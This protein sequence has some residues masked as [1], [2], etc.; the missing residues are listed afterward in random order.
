MLINNSHILFET[1]ASFT[2]GRI[3]LLLTPPS[4]TTTGIQSV[5]SDSEDSIREKRRV[6]QDDLRQGVSDPPPFAPPI[7]AL[8]KR[9]IKR[10]PDEI[11]TQPSIYDDPQKAEYHRPHPKYEN[12]YRFDPAFTWT[13]GEEKVGPSSRLALELRTPDQ[14]GAVI[15]S[16][17]GLESDCGGLAC[18][19]GP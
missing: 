1:G 9:S 8:F 12:L 16:E 15:G 18:V 4:M 2:L 17:D 6:Y 11:A 7:L 10:N 3:H 5:P 14:N 13:W 19:P